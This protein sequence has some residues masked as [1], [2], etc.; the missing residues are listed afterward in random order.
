MSALALAVSRPVHQ[1]KEQDGIG[2]C[3]SRLREVARSA[4][5]AFAPDQCDQP[6]SDS[7]A[8]NASQATRMRCNTVRASAS[9]TSGL[10]MSAA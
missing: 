5:A 7:S 4:R 10:L 1:A 3:H 2:S 6:A 8:I 9:S